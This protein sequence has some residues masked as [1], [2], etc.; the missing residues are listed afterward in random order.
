MLTRETKFYHPIATVD[1]FGWY[2]MTGGALYVPDD[3]SLQKLFDDMNKAGLIKPSDIRK[4]E[5]YSGIYYQAVNA[6]STDYHLSLGTFNMYFM[7]A[8]NSYIPVGMSDYYNFDPQNRGW[9]NE[10]ITTFGRD[11]PGVYFDILGGITP[12]Q[13]YINSNYKK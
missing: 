5:G 8:G 11:W 13:D 9:F 12:D 1:F 3:R 4:V 10:A 2:S 7:A 6:N